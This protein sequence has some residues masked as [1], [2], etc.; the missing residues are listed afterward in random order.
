VKEAEVRCSWW[1][2]GR[3]GQTSRSGQNGKDKRAC[4]EESVKEIGL[5]W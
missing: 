4:S 1:N 2:L 3:E 5:V